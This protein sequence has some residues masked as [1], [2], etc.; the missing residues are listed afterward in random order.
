MENN[1]ESNSILKMIPGILQLNSKTIYGLTSRNVPI[2]RF[3]PLNTTLPDYLVGCSLKDRSSNML[4][5]VQKSETQRTNLIRLIG[6][7]GNLQS[8]REALFFQYS[9]NEWKKFDKSKIKFP[10]ED[11]REF[12]KGYTFNIDPE[13]CKD[14]DDTITI[15]EDQIIY[16]TIA[17]V[18][19]WMNVNPYLFE[20]A[21]KIGQTLYEN[22]KVVAPLLP[23]EEECSLLPKEQRLG[24]SLKFK[25][26]GKQIK[27]ISFQ[28]VNIVNNISL[29]YEEAQ[30][31]Q[32]SNL[33]KEIASYLAGVELKDSHE[34]IEQFMIFYNCEVA[35]ML[36]DKK[37]GI[38]RFQEP[39]D[40]EKLNE[41][42]KIGIN[43]LF[44]ANK[45]AKYIS[46]LNPKSHWGLNKEYYCHATSP[47]R[48]FADIVNQMVLCDYFVPGINY[49]ELNELQKNFKKYERDSFF[50]SQILGTDCRHV[51]GITLSDHRVWVPTWNKII[52]CKNTSNPGTTGTLKYSLDMNQPTW[53]TKMVFKFEDTNC[54]E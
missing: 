6:P 14:I 4:A 27:D 25:W 48:R 35:K 12:V 36:V 3:K 1:I 26:T 30:S 43:Q 22:G 17:D 33:L 2:Y 24:L 38:L 40:I 39:T 20:R 52:T 51:E 32:Y 50:L 45:S 19:S 16:I 11:K 18:G 21:S 23:I 47:I 53:K 8:E 42:K 28:K 31:F 15:S 41:Y 7:C 9:S 10:M 44:L 49:D 29:T 37:E 54:Q 13:G 5:L 34:W 46:A